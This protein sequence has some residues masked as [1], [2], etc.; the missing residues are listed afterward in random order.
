MSKEIEMT[1]RELLI[2]KMTFADLDDLCALLSGSEVM[3]YI[4]PPF[5]K[6]PLI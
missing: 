1:S 5:S 2:R 6:E 4:E 3:R